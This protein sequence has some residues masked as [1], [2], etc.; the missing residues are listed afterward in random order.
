MVDS[1]QSARGSARTMMFASL[2]SRI[3]GFVKAILLVLAIGGTSAVVGGQAFEVA[4]SAPTNLFTLIAGGALG[5]ILVP[6][7]VRELQLGSAGQESV[8]RMVTAVM[9]AAGALTVILT[10]CAPLIVWIYAASWSDEWRGLAIAMAYWCIPQVFFLVVYAVLSQ[11][12]Y[13]RE[14]FGVPAWAPAVSNLIGIIGLAVFLLV[15]P[16]GLGDVNSWTPVMIAVLCG[17]A[18]LGVA[19]Q[20]VMLSVSLRKIGFR[21]RFGRKLTGF[22][23]AP[24]LAGWTFLG[25]LAGQLAYLV[26]SN[27]AS[28]AGETLNTIGVDA[29]SLNSLSIAYLLVLLP[30][31][32]IT[33]SL[34]TSLYTR[35]STSA[36]HGSLHEIEETADKATH[37]VAYV[38]VAATAFFVL[39]GPLIT[40]VIWGTPVIG[41][42]L[43]FLSIGLLGFSQAYVL[44][45]TSFALQD[46]VG[47]FITQAVIAA[48]T[49]VG[50]F[51]ALLFLPVQLMVLGIALSISIANLAGWLTARIALGNTL[52]KLDHSLAGHGSGIRYVRLLVAG[53]VAFFA[54]KALLTVVPAPTAWLEQVLLLAGVGGLAG[55]VYVATA[56]LLGDRT[57]KD[58]LAGLK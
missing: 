43:Q 40:E 26:I 21:P 23:H 12:L 10:V 56:S 51:V 27:V 54:G 25:V 8:E 4:N 7:I 31:G 22:K 9:L 36:A 14:V 3:L 50:A 49:A 16:S 1:P 42:V 19:T 6:Q 38:S 47:P 5:A 28:H 30:H 18:T 45:R 20:A 35:M 37:P 41:Y 39:L 55:V 57:I 44:N 24:R 58:I 32:I 53:L 46:A 13:A 15:L 11:V 48:I 2:S 29:P 34:T 17:S 33:V 52:R